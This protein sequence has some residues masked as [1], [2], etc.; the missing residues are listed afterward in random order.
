[1][2]GSAFHQK[3]QR[4]RRKVQRN[5]NG[6]GNSLVVHFVEVR[7]AAVDGYV[8][9]GPEE[10]GRFLFVPHSG[11]PDLIGNEKRAG[12]A[13]NEGEGKRGEIK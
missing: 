5:G 8:R 12:S 6:N 13:R 1:M 4:R 7:E 9:A 2:G 10:G 3:T 11:E